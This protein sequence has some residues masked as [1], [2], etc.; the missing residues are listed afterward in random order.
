MFVKVGSIKYIYIEYDNI[1]HK[2]IQGKV[3]PYI[4]PC[5]TTKV[6]VQVYYIRM[7]V[8][9]YVCIQYTITSAW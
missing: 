3:S 4:S 6:Q 9:Q 1:T 2:Q 8:V 5:T 7:Y